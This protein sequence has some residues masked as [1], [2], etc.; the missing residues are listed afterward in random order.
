MVNAIV[1]STKEDV[2][3]CIL[4]LV[5]VFFARGLAK[6]KLGGCD[7]CQVPKFKVESGMNICIKN[8]NK[9][10]GSNIFKNFGMTYP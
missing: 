9:I 5:F 10:K 1:D 8:T 4:F 3:S 7:N 2:I 6:C